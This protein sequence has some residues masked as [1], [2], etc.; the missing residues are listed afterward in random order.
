[1]SFLGGTGCP[2]PAPCSATTV[3]PCWTRH[4]LSLHH[5]QMA[6]IGAPTKVRSYVA[7]KLPF[8][9]WLQIGHV[10]T[11]PSMLTL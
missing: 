6:T 10:S 8:T 7:L 3:L 11:T 5:Y 9:N 1:M 2:R 4:S